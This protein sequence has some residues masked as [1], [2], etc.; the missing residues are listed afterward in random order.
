L[1][2]S[3]LDGWR[4]PLPRGLC[5]QFLLAAH[6]QKPH[7]PTALPA[8]KT[9]VPAQ[10]PPTH[11]PPSHPPAT[12]IHHHHQLSPEP[13][14][15]RQLFVRL[16]S[17]HPPPSTSAHLE[18]MA[19]V[20]VCK[21]PT[22]VQMNKVESPVMGWP[23]EVSEHTH[24]HTHQ[25]THTHARVSATCS[26]CVSMRARR[27]RSFS[28]SR[29]LFCCSLRAAFPNEVSVSCG[30]RRQS[31]A[32][33]WRAQSNDGRVNGVAISVEPP[34]VCAPVHRNTHQRQHMPTRL[35][36]LAPISGPDR[37]V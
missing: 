20:A 35:A 3:I 13:I 15:L 22:P 29:A 17:K 12:H 11:P 9:L 23:S 21:S 19:G 14:P 2:V 18:A 6:S 27:I 24:T 33:S 4:W 1:E 31:E 25:H 36:G 32:L 7:N 5:N 34:H 10:H 8:A 26:F 37:C 28:V 16:S 30:E